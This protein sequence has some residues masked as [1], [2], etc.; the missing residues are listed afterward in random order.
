[1][2]MRARAARHWA[3][4]ISAASAWAWS[5]CLP[6]PQ[7][8]DRTKPTSGRS[9]DAGARFECSKAPATVDQKAGSGRRLEIDR[10]LLALSWVG[11]QL[12]ADL[13]AFVQGADAGA[14]D[15]RNVDE[16][17]GSA[18]IRLDEAEALCGIEPFDCAGG[19]CGW[20]L[21]SRVA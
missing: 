7:C 9:R 14:L 16:D 5:F 18:P 8:L 13:L 19:H 1:M 2:S 17:V 6:A 3:G 10:R 21:F 11:L 4:V 12:V 20:V 15:R